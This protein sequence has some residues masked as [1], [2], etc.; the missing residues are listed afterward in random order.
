MTTINIEQ[1]ELLDFIIE[2]PEDDVVRLVYA[3][4]LE[5]NNQLI[6]AQFIR[7][8]IEASVTKDAHLAIK[9]TNESA[10]LIKDYDWLGLIDLRDGKLPYHK[11]L[12]QSEFSGSQRF[13]FDSVYYPRLVVVEIADRKR[14]ISFYLHRGLVAGVSCSVEDWMR[15]GE[16]LAK[17]LPLEFYYPNT[18][19]ANTENQHY[20][21][22]YRDIDRPYLGRSEIRRSDCI[23]ASV[24]DLYYLKTGRS[25]GERFDTI[26]KAYVDASKAFIYWAKNIR[27][28]QV[29]QVC[30]GS[31]ACRLCSGQGSC[32]SYYPGNSY[33]CQGNGL[34]V[35]CSGKGYTMKDDPF[36]I[37]NRPQ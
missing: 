33:A 7:L 27:K 8:Q 31:R 6:P 26:E 17:Q 18:L 29:C 13:W 10:T 21:H 35:S 30:Q 5:E 2:H 16:R 12:S 19:F 11:V 34:C 14:Q 24:W 23:P 28:C 20:F 25:L 36:V 15:F 3:D 22:F 9:K 4:W 32:A 37:M 1:Q